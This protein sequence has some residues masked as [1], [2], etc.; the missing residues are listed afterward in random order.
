M[1]RLSDMG[2]KSCLNSVLRCLVS[3]EELKNYFCDKKEV[4]VIYKS[5]QNK[6]LS[7]AIQRLFVHIYLDNRIPIYKPESIQKVLIEQKS[8]PCLFVKHIPYYIFQACLLI[9]RIR[10]VAYILHITLKTI[11]HKIQIHVQKLTFY[12]LCNTSDI[13]LGSL[14]I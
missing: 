7:F 5:I 11:N 9:L 12:I 6:R 8:M 2:N 4:D 3:I 1:T 10:I 13:E 14:V